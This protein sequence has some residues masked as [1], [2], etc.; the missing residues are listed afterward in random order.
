M[1]AKRKEGC[2]CRKEKA[3]V[4][5]RQPLSGLPLAKVSRKGMSGGPASLLS[6]DFK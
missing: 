5:G 4:L 3:K 6:A 1:M 2:R